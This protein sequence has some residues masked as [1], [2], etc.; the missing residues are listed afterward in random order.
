M[1]SV[2]AWIGNRRDIKKCQEDG[3]PKTLFITLSPRILGL[4]GCHIGVKLLSATEEKLN[5]NNFASP[6]K[7]CSR[8]L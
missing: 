4:V 7:T 1:F 3:P 8:L 5:I 2:T 6:S